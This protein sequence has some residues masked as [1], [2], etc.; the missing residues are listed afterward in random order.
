MLKDV[1][2]ALFAAKM[3]NFS[4]ILKQRLADQLEN[5]ISIIKQLYGCPFNTRLFSADFYGGKEEVA[6]KYIGRGKLF[7]WLKNSGIYRKQ[8]ARFYAS[9][10]LSLLKLI[11]GKRIL[12]P[13]IS[14]A[15]LFIFGSIC[16]PVDR[17]SIMSTEWNLSG[18]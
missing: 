10:I 5:E 9:E 3:L 17:R 12:Y 1:F 15:N 4:K 13:V 18:E 14:P 7:Y 8:K 2:R 11:H 16:C 6:L